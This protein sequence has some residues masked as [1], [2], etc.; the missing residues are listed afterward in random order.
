MWPKIPTAQFSLFTPRGVRVRFPRTLAVYKTKQRWRLPSHRDQHAD[1][2]EREGCNVAQDNN[3]SAAELQKAVEKEQ[4]ASVKAGLT[5]EM[6]KVEVPELVMA[7][8]GATVKH[9]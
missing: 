2:D 7:S 4:L 3:R 5:L 9:G 1:Q 8:L 6:S